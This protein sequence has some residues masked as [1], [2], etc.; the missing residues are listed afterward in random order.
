MYA[1]R[2]HTPCLRLMLQYL[3]EAE[4]AENGGSGCGRNSSSSSSN[5]SGAFVAGRSVNVPDADGLTPLHHAALLGKSDNCRLL[6]KAG[7]NQVS[8]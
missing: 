1:A 6:L 3:A 4:E 7:C 2:A 5:S 8:V